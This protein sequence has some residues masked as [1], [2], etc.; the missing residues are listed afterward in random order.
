M[1]RFLEFEI[2]FL[3]NNYNNVVKVGMKFWENIKKK[4]F[5]FEVYLYEL[6]KVFWGMFIFSY[7]GI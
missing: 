6:E 2:E 5:N 1:I 4:V 3:R 7:K